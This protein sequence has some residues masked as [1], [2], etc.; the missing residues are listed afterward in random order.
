MGIITGKTTR[1]PADV[2]TSRGIT[3]PTRFKRATKHRVNTTS[4]SG[5]D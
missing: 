2:L 1:F 3:E 4:P 5:T